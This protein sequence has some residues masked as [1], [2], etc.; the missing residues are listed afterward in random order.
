MTRHNFTDA[1]IHDGR[2]RTTDDGAVV[3]AR[4]A[5]SGNVQAYLGAE[6]GDTELDIVRVYRPSDAVFAKDAIASYARKPITLGHPAGGVSA[7]T[8]R[9]LAVGEIDRDVMRDGEFVSV[10]LLFRDAKAIAMLQSADGP[11]ELS[12]GYDAQIKFEDGVSPA[13]EQYDAIMTDFRMNHVAVV[14]K[15]RGGEELRIGD[16]AATWGASP[17]VHVADTKGN[18]MS[19]QTVV[20]GDQAAQVAIAD[21]PKVETFKT[22]MA[23]RLTDMETSHVEILATA[24]AAKDAEIAKANAAKDAAEA[25]V[26]LDADIDQRVADRAD[27]ISTAKSVASDVKTA[28]LSDADIRKAVVIAKL[29]DSMAEKPDAYIDARFDIL[30]EDAAEA[31]KSDPVAKALKDGKPA[32]KIVDLDTVYSERNTSLSDAW[33]APVKKEA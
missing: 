22:D 17:L 33:K 14:S 24:I 13:G 2:I 28:G 6:I 15:A 1:L 30:A 12:M 27:L 7:N 11:R 29:G 26:L 20:L 25:K 32:P 19:L 3:Q 18:N 9:D 10:P 21:A 8:W 4:V 31:A 16:S 5:R 23:K